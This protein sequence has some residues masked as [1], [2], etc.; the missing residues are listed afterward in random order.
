MSGP[1]R[2]RSSD[3][4][5]DALSAQPDSAF[6]TASPVSWSRASPAMLPVVFLPAPW[7][8]SWYASFALWAPAAQPARTS[9]ST[10]MRTGTE[11]PRRRPP[12][13][14]T[15]LAVSNQANVQRIT[16]QT[17]SV[18]CAYYPGHG[19]L[20]PRGT[21]G[22]PAI[23]ACKGGGSDAPAVQDGVAVGKVVEVTRKVT[24]TRGGQTR[25][26]DAR[27]EVSGDDVVETAADGRVTIVLAHNN[28]T[29]A[30]GPGKKSKVSESPAWALAKV[31]VPR[32]AS[33]R[34]RRPPVVTPSARPRPP[35]RSRSCAGGKADDRHPADRRCTATD[36]AADAGSGSGCGAGPGRSRAAA[37]SAES[38][39]EEQ[40]RRWRGARPAARERWRVAE[41]FAVGAV[42]WWRPFGGWSGRHPAAE[43]RGE[44][45]DDGH[46][47]VR[48]RRGRRR[49]EGEVSRRGRENEDHARRR[50]A[51]RRVLRQSRRIKL[52]ADPST[53]VM[54]NL[55]K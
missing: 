6:A 18:A 41:A 10:A 23:P 26:L 9:T 31:I 39:R 29:W 20:Y 16:G 46:A 17:R 7:W 50:Q 35:T 24:A 1:C 49:A 52:T 47:R 38:G 4:F 33:T 27:S 34:P 13:R 48:H 51:R 2:S 28:A 43:E 40:G 12:P 44:P 32:A 8:C 5:I 42:G 19:A 25:T 11:C 37:S 54:M 36:R 22:H 15:H 55:K 30:L 14:P 3:R 21:A 45:R 53:D